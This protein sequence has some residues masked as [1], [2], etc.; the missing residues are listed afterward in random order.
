M[1]VLVNKDTKVIIQGITGTSGSVHA[2]GCIEYG[3]QIVGGVRPGAGRVEGYAARPARSEPA[4]SS[5][6]S[7]PIARRPIQARTSSLHPAGASRAYRTWRPTFRSRTSPA[8][9]KTL[10]CRDTFGCGQPSASTR[11]S[12]ITSRTIWKAIPEPFNPWRETAPPTGQG[13]KID[14]EAEQ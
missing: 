2:R 4:D 1:S 3:T 5:G 12:A 10:R 14:R 8:S 9:F 13:Q 6:R 11:S 7:A